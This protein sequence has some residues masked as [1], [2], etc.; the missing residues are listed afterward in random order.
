MKPWQAQKGFTIL[1]SG[2]TC[3]RALA[4]C[5]CDTSRALWKLESCDAKPRLY[6]TIIA[7][8]SGMIKRCT[9]GLL[10]WVCMQ[11][12]NATHGINCC[13]MMVVH[14]RNR[15]LRSDYMYTQSTYKNT[16]PHSNPLILCSTKVMCHFCCC[17][18]ES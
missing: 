5:S 9:G 6:H 17:C 11:S 14:D 15:G 13:W 8:Y 18:T 12:M 3:T 4:G 1:P 7:A 10:A 2:A 16:F